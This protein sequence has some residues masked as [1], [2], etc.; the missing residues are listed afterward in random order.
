[1][2][3][4]RNVLALSELQNACF[5]IAKTGILDCENMVFCAAICGILQN[6]FL[7]I[8]LRV[9]NSAA[10]MRGKWVN[11]EVESYFISS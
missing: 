8:A 7:V 11:L 10:A 9:I 4:F 1:M 3:M 5:R 2:G 6:R